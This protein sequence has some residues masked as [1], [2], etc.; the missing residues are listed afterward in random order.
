MMKLL[1]QWRKRTIETLSLHPADQHRC[2]KLCGEMA[3]CAAIGL[4]ATDDAYEALR[5]W[6]AG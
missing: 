4:S 1:S 2:A 6:N 5:G 3:C